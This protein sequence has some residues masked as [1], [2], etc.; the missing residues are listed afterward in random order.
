MDKVGRNISKYDSV[1][2]GVMHCE[3]QAA[4]RI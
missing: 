2:E 3:Q 1:I 4:F